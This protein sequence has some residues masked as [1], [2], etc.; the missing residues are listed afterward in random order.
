MLF[1][2]IRKKCFCV[3]FFSFFKPAGWFLRPKNYKLTCKRVT[4]DFW[5]WI[6][7]DPSHNT[8]LSQIPTFI[9]LSLRK[10]SPLPLC[11]T[12]PLFS[13]LS[14]FLP[15]L[16]PRGPH[17]DSGLSLMS[18]PRTVRTCPWCLFWLYQDSKLLS[19]PVQGPAPSSL[20]LPCIPSPLW[21]HSSLTPCPRAF[22][23]A[24]LF[25]WTH[26]LPGS[27]K[28]LF[29]HLYVFG[30][31]IWYYP[32]IF[33]QDGKECYKILAIKEAATGLMK[34]RTPAVLWLLVGISVSHSKLE[35]LGGG[36]GRTDPRH[37]C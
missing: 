19:R 5:S 11:F 27:C 35:T 4:C 24:V 28:G 10:A 21:R 31:I 34:L 1:F 17:G 22:A 13:Y 18:L 14:P 36:E 6:R 7:Q 30:P 3:V 20:L 12:L 37:I 26:L 16:F 29:L 15:G 33:F 2:S 32:W 23:Q 25:A 9:F 8:H